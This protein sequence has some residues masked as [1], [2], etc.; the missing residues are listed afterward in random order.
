M[1]RRSRYRQS[2]RPSVLAAL[3]GLAVLAIVAT[4]LSIVAFV[5]T[6]SAAE[7]GPESAEAYAF[8]TPTP[9]P[10]EVAYVGDSFTGGSPGVG[11][12]DEMGWPA[13]LAESMGWKFSKE[14]D[15]WSV[16]GGTGYL[17]HGDASESI[18]DRIDD[19]VGGTPEVVVIAAGAND[20]QAYSAEETGAAA[21]S[22]FTAVKAALPSARIIVIGPFYQTTPLSAEVVAT[23]DAIAAASER[24]A[25]EFIDPLPWVE[26]GLIETGSDRVH[27]TDAGHASIARL[28]KEALPA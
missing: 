27:P 28:I 22:V 23:R 16:K 25:V 18:V 20:A 8:P 14:P 10:T 21:E 26:A 9:G 5:S 6:R 7:S 11:G 2:G 19:I 12:V 1:G 24:A 13:I 15:M 4:G 3:A 17:R